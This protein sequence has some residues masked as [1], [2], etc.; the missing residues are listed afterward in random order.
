MSTS[1]S[2]PVV[3]SATRTGL[4]PWAHALLQLATRR[5]IALTAALFIALMVC[6]VVLWKTIPCNILDLS[7]GETLGGE[8]LLLFGLLIRSWAAGS[9]V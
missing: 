2:A 9:L 4:H 7:S 6:D 3:A 8:L 5:R 1:A